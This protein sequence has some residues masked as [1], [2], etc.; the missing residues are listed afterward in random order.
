M[1]ILG[2]L[3]I[4]GLCGGSVCAEP[5]ATPAVT[6]VEAELLADLE[7]R[8]LKP[9][10]TLYAKVTAEWNGLG[11]V[12]LRGAV[13]EAK[14]VSV[15]PHSKTSKASEVS[16]S[17]TNAEC[18]KS[19]MEPFALDLVALAAP[20]E[21]DSSVSMDMPRALGSTAP[22]QGSGSGFRSMTSA[23][24][25][26]W[27]S[28]QYLIQADKNLR[29]GS[30]SGI[31]GLKLSV[32]TGPQNSSVLSSN[33][34]NVALDKHTMLL[35]VP[36]STVSDQAKTQGS[37]TPEATPGGAQNNGPTA[38]QPGDSQ[39]GAASANQNQASQAAEEDI[40]TCAPPECSIDLAMSEP[41]SDRHAAASISL[42]QLGYV[43]REQREM[44]A[45][46]QDETL[47]YLSP[48]E[49]L[50]TFNPHPLV[51]RHGVT[52]PGST[53]RV[54]RAALVDVKT[55]RVTSTVDWY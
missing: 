46:N 47:N 50:V 33:D 42:Q 16:L 26:I 7:A 32:G 28:M 24:S 43:S 35:L 29:A 8:N 19:A 55:S 45:L 18:G 54:I 15:V 9:G 41:E 48:S 31:K 52:T 5:L 10:G 21:D 13:L 38:G 39:T 2:I 44:S 20:E 36:G 27:W 40:E 30:V 4:A 11:C 12:L 37:G 53:V 51:P 17:F 49:L 23:N 34:R 22:S 3:L 25:D 14:V 1:R 6:V